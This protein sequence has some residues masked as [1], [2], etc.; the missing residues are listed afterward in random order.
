VVVV[1]GPAEHP[2]TGVVLLAQVTMYTRADVV[3]MQGD[4]VLLVQA[5]AAELH[6]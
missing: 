2:G 6:L 3:E 1:P 4:R 5:E